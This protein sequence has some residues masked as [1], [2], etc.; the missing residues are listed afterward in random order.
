MPLLDFKKQF[1]QLVESGEKRQT[2]RAPRKI[3][4]LKGDITCLI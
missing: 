3:P 1:A 2:I 4:I